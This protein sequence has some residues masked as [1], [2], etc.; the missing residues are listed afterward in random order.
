MYVFSGRYS[1]TLSILYTKCLFHWCSLG[2]EINKLSNCFG[3]IQWKPRKSP[4]CEIYH[5]NISQ[6][7]LIE[8]QASK[9][10]YGKEK[11][12]PFFKKAHLFLRRK[13]HHHVFYNVNQ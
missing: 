2:Y 7:S 3:S 13:M 8:A 4:S 12:K 9:L 5:H 10:H 6:K 1:K 11:Q